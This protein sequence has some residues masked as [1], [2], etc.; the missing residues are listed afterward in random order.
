[1]FY[2]IEFEGDINMGSVAKKTKAIRRRKARANKTN[3][4][5]NL[6]RIQKNQEILSQLAAED[7][8]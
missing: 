4:K 8:A 2:K 3:L 1:M 7:K 5:D 6:K